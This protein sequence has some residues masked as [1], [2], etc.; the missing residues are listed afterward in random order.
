[1]TESTETLETVSNSVYQNLVT[2]LIHDIVS[3][4]T[5]REKLL[6]SRYPDYK[7][8]YYDPKN[9]LDIHGQPKQQDSSQYFMCENCGR[10][11]SGNRFAAHLQ[12]CLSRGGRR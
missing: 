10:E 12:R 7:P 2:T 5:T 9:Q 4:E 11:V 8:Y 1:M 6:R 3:R